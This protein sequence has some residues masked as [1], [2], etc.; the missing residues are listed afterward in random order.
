MAAWDH[1]V[2]EKKDSTF[3]ACLLAGAIYSVF[4]VLDFYIF[5]EVAYQFLQLRAIVA[6]ACLIVA[7]I[8]WLKPETY[9][10]LSQF[11][12]ISTVLLAGIGIVTMTYLIAGQPNDNAYYPGMI[13]VMACNFIFVPIRFRYAAIVGLTLIAVYN[14]SQLL[15]APQISIPILIA[16]NFFLIG[17]GLI[18]GRTCFDTENLLLNQY[19]SNVLI[20]Q[21]KLAIA[22]QKQR[23]DELLHSILPEPIADRLIVGTPN[24]ADAYAD[25][26]VLF[27]DLAKFTELSNTVS[28]R[29]LVRILNSIFSAF[30]EVAESCGVEKIKTI[31]DA[32]M[33]ACGVPD[34][35]EDH[36]ERILRL[37]LGMCDAVAVMRKELPYFDLQ[38]RIGI[39][40]GPCIAGV[41]GRKRF[42]Y[43]LWGDT[44]N[45]ASR[46]ESNGLPGRVQVSEATYL[47]TKH[48]YNFEER[49]SIPIKGRGMMKTYI[50]VG[51][52]P[53][54]NSEVQN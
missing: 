27:A 39:H 45:L 10:Y 52:L 43:D 54:E 37:A 2:R 46:M 47:R 38:V 17:A 16:N 6:S 20:D 13:L 35:V 8:I 4:G 18:F 19:H 29:N 49:G 50:L 53:M 24:I 22:K 3:A 48:L 21:Q 36:P 34:E 30:D 44:V 26:T 12:L 33:A 31:G 7:T 15:V 25:V 1:I 28:P 23:A 32:Y 40:T 9:I 42:I 14:G 51:I 5:P 41:I 11:L